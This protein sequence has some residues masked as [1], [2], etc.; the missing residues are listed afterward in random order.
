M[1][2]HNLPVGQS[3]AFQFT[4]LELTLFVL[5]LIT[6][7]LS[8]IELQCQCSHLDAK[9]TTKIKED[10]NL[11]SKMRIWDHTRNF[12]TN[13]IKKGLIGCPNSC[14]KSKTIRGSKMLQTIHTRKT[15]F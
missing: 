3:Q 5:S 7:T 12:K 4:I 6:I 1:K 2:S 9:I 15:Q 13:S 11:E 8:K 14:S 10:P